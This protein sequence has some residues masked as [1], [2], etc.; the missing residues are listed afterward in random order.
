M[1]KLTKTPTLTQAVNAGS[2]KKIVKAVNLS[3]EIY[4]AK[5]PKAPLVCSIEGM[6]PLEV[7]DN[8]SKLELAEVELRNLKMSLVGLKGKTRKI[9]IAMLIAKNAFFRNVGSTQ[10]GEGLI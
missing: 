1:K 3:V 7:L 5:K 2:I 10:N 8:E 4:P 6:V 9:D